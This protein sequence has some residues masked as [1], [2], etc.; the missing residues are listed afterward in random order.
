[1]FK[2]LTQVWRS[3]YPS[4]EPSSQDLRHSTHGPGPLR[5]VVTGFDAN[6]KSTVVMDGAPPQRA[7]YDVAGKYH[8]YNAWLLHSVPA[9]LNAMSDPVI[10]GHDRTEPPE[11]GVVIRI[12]TLMPGFAW[13]MHETRTIDFGIVLSGKIELGLETGT[14]LLHPGDIVVQRGTLHSWRPVD[15]PCT[16]VFVLADAKARSP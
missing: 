1:M 9:D 8:G 4:R 15:G 14:V 7:T 2:R 11:G 10:D 16:M 3:V 6:G 12:T 5:R 13:P